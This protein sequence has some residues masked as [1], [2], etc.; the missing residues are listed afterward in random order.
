MPLTPGSRIGS[1]EIVA[2]IG[3][4]GMGEVHRARDTRLG[5]DVAIKALPAE[6]AQDPER[7]A[8][9]E[10]EARLLASLSHPNIA[11]I[12]G[13]EEA[14]GTRYLVLEFVD[15][16]TLAQRLAR[17]P[18]PMDEAIEVARQI[19]AGVEAAHESGV[20]HR[21]LKPGNVMLTAGDHVKVLDF[22][23]ARSGGGERTGSDV[24]L[25]SSPTRTYAATQA[26]V[27]LG[28][29]AYMSPEQARGKSVDRRTDIWSFGCVLFECLTGRP[30]FDGET[31]SDLIAKILQTEPDWSALPAETPARVRALLRRC[32]RRDPKERLRDI[33]DARL[34]LSE[35]IAGGGADAPAAAP[36]ARGASGGVW[37]W[38][39]AVAAV[40]AIACAALLVLQRP[41]PGVLT[42]LELPSP[43]DAMID[44]FGSYAISPD[45]R[46]V[47]FLQP[48]KDTKPAIVL[49]DLGQPGTRALAGTEGA[50][51]PFWSPDGRHLG[52]FAEGKLR[53]IPA[54]GGGVQN[55][56][57]V[58]TPRGGS[59]GRGEIVF[60]PDAVSP[61]MRVAE[62]GGV[63]V[64][65]TVLD[66]TRGEA[67]HRFPTFLPD[68][69][70]FVFTIQSSGDD[71][72]RTIRVGSLDDPEV[73]VIPVAG[74][75]PTFAAPDVILFV[76]D[77]TVMAQRIDLRSLQ[78]RGAA[79][80][81][82]S[83]AGTTARI[84]GA[85]VGSASHNGVLVLSA[86]YERPARLEWHHPEGRVEP[87]TELE[88][89]LMGPSLSPDGRRVALVEVASGNFSTW[90]V[91]LA[92]GAVSSIMKRERGLRTP[93][94]SPDG[95]RIAGLLVDAG[96]NELRV[97]DLARGTDELLV[98]SGNE[99][100]ITTDWS[101]AA[102]AILFGLLVEGHGMDLHYV[103]LDGAP[104]LQTYLA[105]PANE[106]GAVL[107]PDGRWI[108]YL[109]DASGTFDVIVDRFPEPANAR[110]VAMGAPSAQISI[111]NG[112]LWWAG[113]GRS[114]MY[115]RFD[116]GDVVVL[117]VRTDPTLAL[118]APRPMLDL[119]DQTYGLD[120]DP[121]G[122]RFLV[123][124]PV[125]APRSSLVVIQN[126]ERQLEAAR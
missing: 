69:R 32:L 55:L 120:Y 80:V 125:G 105:T 112:Q 15:G 116:Q 18:L 1:F 39:A 77:A 47:A 16:E 20:I 67:S 72:E 28:T 37:R 109:S 7:L 34:E 42:R 14:A 8:R 12:F 118:G 63:P 113:D 88:R 48:G 36:A 9:F 23:L 89:R 30:L 95:T 6:F 33:G 115:R 81:L 59:W 68:G 50:S 65:V 103:S 76:R 100:G 121:A 49:R 41:E 26:G 123:A 94:W 85:P 51:F 126:W 124:L 87:V 83:D 97:F 57:D 17:G 53:R 104:T 74:S 114:L 122:R 25:T 10:R 45:G 60:A 58:P 75:S 84:S 31:V 110:R 13:V 43:T 92:D 62:T 64:A 5:R 66:S 46:T 99:W 22:G 52:F 19:A 96:R 108:A 86:D 44:V 3:A 70:R 106:A 24:N 93:V 56:C 82:D 71:R 91:D 54:A 79:V 111:W 117:D 119:P 61:L 107:S 78:P 98:E 2:P 101:A 38:I 35:I 4:G 73:A 90:L 40:I 102:N 11:G 29:A 27:V 21:D